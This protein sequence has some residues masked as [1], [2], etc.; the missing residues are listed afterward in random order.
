[1]IKSVILISFL[2]ITPILNAT[3][4]KDS[5]LYGSLGYTYLSDKYNSSTQSTSEQEKL[6]QEYKLGYKGII[7]SPKLLDYSL[8]GIFRYEDI[9]AKANGEKTDTK[10]DSRDY[11]VNLNVLK[12]SKIPFRVYAQ[13][14]DRPIS[15]V[16][17][18]T[19][20]RSLNDTQSMGI[21]G[22][23]KLNIFDLT[24]SALDSSA[25]YES[26]LST[27]ERDTQTYRTSLR[28]EEKEY[29]LQLSYSNIEQQIGK[30]YADGNKTIRKNIDDDIRLKYNWR[31]NDVLSL[32]TNSYYK[33]NRNT[34]IDITSTSTA[35]TFAS[36][37]LNWSPKTKHRGSINIQT[38]NIQ[39]DY[40]TTKS[41]SLSQNYGFRMTKNINFTQLANYN[42]VKS[43]NMS[44]QSINL[45]SGVSHRKVIGK[46]T[47]INTSLNVSARSNSTD[48]N[49]TSN[50]NTYTYDLKTS[51]NQNMDSINSILN[52]NLGYYGST[53]TL[54][55]TTERY[56]AG[57]S[58]R[59]VFFSVI[60]NNLSTSYYKDETKLKYFDEIISRNI[61]RLE[62]EDNINH[63]TKIGIKGSLLTKVGIRY[64]NIETDGKKTD[65]LMP[66]AD[67]NFKYRLGT[68]LN[69]RSNFHISKDMTYNI[70][71]YALS[72]NLAFNTR[73]TK[74]SADYS[75][76]RTV[77]SGSSEYTEISTRDSHRIQLKFERRF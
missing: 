45:G 41:I 76:N 72:N 50:S 74:I 35:T 17:A 51:L 31:I 54:D 66:K 48:S 68:N 8:E 34:S 7:Y 18:N 59:T 5:G 69:F 40:G 46:N 47:N 63:A 9:N 30:E 67:L 29:S 58:L 49:T 36:A 21:S 23:I 77:S 20:N 1:M 55:E 70:T 32:D 2:I 61:T 15:T 38:F 56:S 75:Y 14:S 42:L 12:E 33:I 60:K 64:S 16:Y 28:K 43:D 71:D 37:Y 53:S 13:K 44:S 22:T 6:I 52:V 3:V 19:I 57:L 25:T 62:I 26:L 24:Y 65:R 27:E 11:K 39:S 10:S 73:Y 4:Y